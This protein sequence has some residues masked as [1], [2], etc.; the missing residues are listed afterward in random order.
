MRDILKNIIIYI[1][2][3]EA[4]V[5]LWR[6]K[7]SVVAITG[8]VGKTGTKDA[9]AA[10]LSAKYSVRKSHKSFNSEFGIPLTIL[11]LPNAWGNPIL[12]MKNILL[13]FIKIF[14]GGYEDVLVLEVGADKPGDIATIAGWLKARVVIITAVPEVPVHRE[15]YTDAESILKEKSQLVKALIDGGLLITGDDDRVETI[16][17]LTG[18][19][20][21]LSR[22][23]SEVIYDNNAPVGMGFSFGEYKIYREGVLGEH[24]GYALAFAMAVAKE[25]GICIDDAVDRL[26]NMP[27]TPGRMRL[28]AGKNNCTIIDDSYNSSPEALKAALKALG[29]L[30]IIGKKMA[31][32][33]DMNELGDASDREHRR[34]GIQVAHIADILYT[35]GH[36]AKLLSKA[37]TEEGI[38]SNSVHTYDPGQTNELAKDLVNEISDGDVILIKGSQGGVRLEKVVKELIQDNDRASELLVR[39]EPE[40]LKR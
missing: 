37:A 4:R 12:W 32:L 26:E 28:L 11:G 9:V 40:W 1:L 21:R 19:V 17:S 16:E 25:F 33:G 7:P 8:V 15:F 23:T 36:Q 38:P 20:E 24:Q 10:A 35:L 29:G 5:V 31:V 39:Q 13:G 18:R 27:H 30:N 6:H 2:T 22:G 3:L 34:A 14:L